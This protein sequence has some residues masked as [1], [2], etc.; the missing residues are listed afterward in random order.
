MHFQ[1]S[2]TS[3][4]G[5]VDLLPASLCRKHCSA[6]VIPQ[7][8]VEFTKQVTSS[9]DGKYLYFIHNFDSIWGDSQCSG[10]P[11]QH[12]GM[13]VSSLKL[14]AL[15]QPKAKCL[16]QELPAVLSTGRAESLP[17][18]KWEMPLLGVTSGRQLLLHAHLG[19]EREIICLPSCPQPPPHPHPP[20]LLLLSH[21]KESISC[22]WSAFGNKV[23]HPKEDNLSAFFLDCHVKQFHRVPTALMRVHAVW[24]HF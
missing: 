3:A 5:C 8:L 17:H 14:V 20:Q 11:C 12:T 4:A 24:E 13:I 18:A 7:I 23:V 1:A 21:R 15:Q 6:S 10:F 16:H 22:P 19:P 9:Q 2:G